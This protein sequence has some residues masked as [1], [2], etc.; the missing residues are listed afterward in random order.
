MTWWGWTALLFMLACVLFQHTLVTDALDV[1]TD[2]TQRAI[3]CR[4]QL[5]NVLTHGRCRP[6]AQ[7][8][9]AI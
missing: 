5:C 1:A 4:A 7:D 6:P 3:T 8:Q 9:R 2:A